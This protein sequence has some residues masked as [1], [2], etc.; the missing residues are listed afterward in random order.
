MHISNVFGRKSQSELNILMLRDIVKM[1]VLIT[2]LNIF[3]TGGLLDIVLL[4][5]LNLLC[6]KIIYHLISNIQLYNKIDITIR[7]RQRGELWHDFEISEFSRG[8]FIV[9][10]HRFESPRA[11]SLL[12]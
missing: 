8:V 6:Q 7:W 2:E 10:L 9:K 5:L 1:D 3:M 12:A 11:S 4:L